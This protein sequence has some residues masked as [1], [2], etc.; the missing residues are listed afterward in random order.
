MKIL[1]ILFILSFLSNAL[2]AGSKFCIQVTAAHNFTPNNMKPAVARILNHYDKARIDK[3]TGGLVLRVGNYDK[4]SYALKDL[5]DIQKMYSDAYIRR[6]NYIVSEIIYPKTD[7]KISTQT[8]KPRSLKSQIIQKKVPKISNKDETSPTIKKRVKKRR[9][10]IVNGQVQLIDESTT[11]DSKPKRILTIKKV[12]K[13]N[14]TPFLEKQNKPSIPQESFIYNKNNKYN[15]SFYKD[16][17]RCYATV[18]TES[19][20]KKVPK[21]QKREK[22]IYPKQQKTL[23][24]VETPKQDDWLNNI[25]DD[26][27]KTQEIKKEKIHY[28][29]IEEKSSSDSKEKKDIYYNQKIK[30]KK[31][32]NIEKIIT[33]EEVIAEPEVD[34]TIDDEN[35]YTDNEPLIDEDIFSNDT[36]TQHTIKKQPK[37]REVKKEQESSFFDIFTKDKIDTE[38]EDEYDNIDVDVN[39]DDIE[40][41][42][43]IEDIE[44]IQEVKKKE[45]K[46]ESGFFDFL[47]KPQAK[48]EKYSTPKES[49][50]EENYADIEINSDDIEDYSLLDTEPE[51]KRKNE[52]QEKSGFFDFLKKPVKQQSVQKEQQYQTPKYDDYEPKNNKSSKY[53]LMDEYESDEYTQKPIKK[54]KKAINEYKDEYQNQYMF[55][56]SEEQKQDNQQAYFNQSVM[57]EIETEKTTEELYKNQY[58]FENSKEETLQENEPQE[59]MKRYVEIIKEPQRVEKP[60]KQYVEIVKNPMQKIEKASDTQEDISYKN[61]YMYQHQNTPTEKDNQY[62][63]DDKEDEN[64][65]KNQYMFQNSNDDGGMEQPFFVKEKK[66]DSSNYQYQHS[67]HKRE[68]PEI[69]DDY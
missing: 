1:K 48:T 29:Y 23:I 58:M 17:K 40:E 15:N 42:Y 52:T 13:Y 43:S 19:N 27:E 68:E 45:Q 16:C 56:N 31:R 59:T 38:E 25:L 7:Y 2:L 46:Q 3:R 51:E 34:I 36:A 33:I 28:T 10:V 21:Q 39:M 57:D 65:Y 32:D 22:I 11:R 53:D 69:D 54:V 24:E 62:F 18:E 6:C 37:Y 5:K 41:D 49:K 9:L 63:N 4:Y 26:K 30:E 64:P 67:N 20:S 35:I 8:T 47:K 44:S 61:Q 60:I 12:P 66:D 14:E 50:K 55:Q